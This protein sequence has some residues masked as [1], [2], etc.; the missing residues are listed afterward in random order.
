[1]Q[2]TRFFDIKKQILYQYPL[3]FPP[4]KNFFVS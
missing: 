3:K 2:D 4:F 1:M